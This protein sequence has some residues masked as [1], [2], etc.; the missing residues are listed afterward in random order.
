MIR[1]TDQFD[2]SAFVDFAVSRW[3]FA[4][5]AVAVAVG[6][7]AAAAFLFSPRYTA[8]AS[9]L[10]DSP[11]G[12]DP[13]VATAVSPVYLESLRSYE[14]F[15]SSDSLF[16]EA[17]SA[18]HIREQY[19]GVP[20]ESM[21]SRVLKVHKPRET[22]ILEIS[23]TL[24]DARK[25]QAL[26][27]YMAEKTV[28]LSQTLDRRADE[29]LL[30]SLR[31]RADAAKARALEVER[32]S[33]AVA[34]SEP[35]EGLRSEVSTAVELLGRIRTDL[36]QAKTDLA[37]TQAQEEAARA[38]GADRGY[39]QRLTEQVAALRGR[40][41]ALR[42]EEASAAQAV[43]DKQVLLGKR[44]SDHDRL[45]EEQKSARAE[46]DAANLRLSETTATA[47][48]RSERLKIIDPGIVPE[49]P[50]FPNRALMIAAAALISAAVSLL[51]LAI[52]YSYRLR[53]GS[54]LEHARPLAHLA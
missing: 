47:A 39:R 5:I 42:G 23:V 13:R 9:L 40:I 32:E 45:Q 52:A 54:G 11:A 27:Q 10:I 19:P 35:V 29:D 38:D 1:Q 25:A 44:D 12:A 33:A 49:R 37:E 30:N 34:V 15:A 26:A 28:A 6:I 46:L 50:S 20:L 41:A 7:A 36:Q 14:H 8:T 4:A 2:L 22:K 18:L 24:A 43:Q 31:S 53:R 3:R 16:A 51:Y 48:L 21:K 17:I